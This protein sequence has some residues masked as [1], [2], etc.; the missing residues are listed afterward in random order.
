MRVTKII[1]I[2]LGENPAAVRPRRPGDGE[3]LEYLT[4]SILNRA[5]GRN[6]IDRLGR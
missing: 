2:D 1:T 3:M 6:F 4:L 5:A